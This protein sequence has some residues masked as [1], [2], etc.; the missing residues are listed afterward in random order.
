MFKILDGFENIDYNIF[1][2]IKE[3]KI[4]RG[5]NFIMVKKQSR[6]ELFMFTEDHQCME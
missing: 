5:H 6:L 3:K 4:P 1:Y 2:E